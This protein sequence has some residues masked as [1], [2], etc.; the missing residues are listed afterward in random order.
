MSHVTLGAY[1]WAAELCLV[2]TRLTDS[3]LTVVGGQTPVIHL[4]S[5]LWMSKFKLHHFQAKCHL[6]LRI[7]S[8]SYSSCL[9]FLCSYTP[10]GSVQI[11]GLIL[12]QEQLQLHYYVLNNLP[13]KKIVVQLSSTI[14]N[15]RDHHDLS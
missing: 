7:C 11:L 13:A 5:Y 8:S 3:S 6:D 10:M 2:L 15:N 1:L 4:H 14:F 12:H 9:I